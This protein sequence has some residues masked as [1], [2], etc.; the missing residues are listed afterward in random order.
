MQIKIPFYKALILIVNQKYCP[1]K[2]AGQIK[3]QKHRVNDAAPPERNTELVKK[4]CKIVRSR[5][6]PCL[7]LV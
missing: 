3:R 4:G 7:S 5:D 2:G 6:R 1:V